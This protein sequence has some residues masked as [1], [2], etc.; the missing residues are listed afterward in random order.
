[1]IQ[2]E[3]KRLKY[4]IKVIT[5]SNFNANLAPEYFQVVKVGLVGKQLLKS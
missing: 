2:G 4:F 1:M 5:E 3:L